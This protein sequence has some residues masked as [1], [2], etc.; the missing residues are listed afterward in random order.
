MIPPIYEPFIDL[1]RSG[2]ICNVSIGYQLANFWKCC[3]WAWVSWS[4]TLRYV[5]ISGFSLSAFSHSKM[6]PY[7]SAF[8]NRVRSVFLISLYLLWNA[9]S[10]FDSVFSLI[11]LRSSALRVVEHHFWK[12]L[13]LNIERFARAQSA[14]VSDKILNLLLWQR[15]RFFAI[16]NIDS[17]LGSP[18][19][20][21]WTSFNF[22]FLSYST[23]PQHHAFIIDVTSC[24]A[25]S[26]L[27]KRNPPWRRLFFWIA[28]N[29]AIST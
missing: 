4:R 14:Q 3:H 13:S 11:F 26:E 28:E 22:S 18:M 9:L 25:F 23:P 24:V 7:F 16:G 6:N 27:E 19:V 17:S 12:V 8:V 29:L 21:N 15:F 2:H 1:L 10:G 20:N 5:V